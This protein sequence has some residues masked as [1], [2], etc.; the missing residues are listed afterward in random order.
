MAR[1]RTVISFNHFMGIGISGSAGGRGIDE[2]KTG[3]E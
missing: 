3:I 1:P 2:S